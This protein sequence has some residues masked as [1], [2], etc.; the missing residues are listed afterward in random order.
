[1]ENK[2]KY[3]EDRIRDFAK[4]YYPLYK[5]GPTSLRSLTKKWDLPYTTAV[6]WFKKAIKRL[7]L[8]DLKESIRV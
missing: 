7:E 1:M 6:S 5:F 8:K 2:R 4:V 3:Y